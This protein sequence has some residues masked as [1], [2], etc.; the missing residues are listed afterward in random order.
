MTATRLFAGLLLAASFATGAA[1]AADRDRERDGR[2]FRHITPTD[3]PCAE[4]RG[5]RDRGDACEVRDTRIGAPGSPLTVDASPNGGIRVEGWDQTEVLVRAVVRTWAETDVETTNGGVNLTVPRDYSA[6]LEVST[7][8]GGL[9]SDLPVTL[10]GGRR[11]E[12]R[13]TLGSGG[14]LIKVKTVNGGVALSAR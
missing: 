11:H 14:P 10:P 8:N 6:A 3:D 5:D 1:V 13:T 2:A 7:V 4:N 9:R 12:I